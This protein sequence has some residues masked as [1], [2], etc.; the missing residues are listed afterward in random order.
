MQEALMVAVLVFHS[1]LA[2]E[3][4]L[5]ESVGCQ[6]MGAQVEGGGG[7]MMNDNDDCDDADDHGDDEADHD[8]HHHGYGYGDADDADEGY[9]RLCRWCNTG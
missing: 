9:H 4:L 8:G 5:F 7:A 3:M 6:A 1:I 2:V